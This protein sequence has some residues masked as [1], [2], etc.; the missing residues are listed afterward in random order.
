[1]YR[2]WFEHADADV[3]RACDAAVEHLTAKG[4]TI[5]PIEIPHLEAIRVAHSVTIVSEMRSAISPYYPSQKEKFGLD[6]RIRAGVQEP[7][8]PLAPPV[9]A[10]GGCIYSCSPD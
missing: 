4:A 3:V 10:S 7:G 6:V 5:V 8:A 1:M 2:E 9:R